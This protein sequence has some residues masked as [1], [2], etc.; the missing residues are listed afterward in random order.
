MATA[1]AVDKARSL[2]EA[3]RSELTAELEQIDQALAGLRGGSRRGPGRPRGSSKGSA[4]GATGKRRRRRR[5]GT[6]AD[7]A[8][9]YLA[10]HPGAGAPE[11]AGALGIKPNYVYRVMA[12]LEADGRVRK[13]GKGYYPVT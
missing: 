5:G 1:T 12:G 2:L 6:R 9:K 7:H 11:I 4:V 3:R 10:D 13:E 8:L